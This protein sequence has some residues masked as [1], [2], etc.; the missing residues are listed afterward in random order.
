[1]YRAHIIGGE[2]RVEED[3][4][5]DDVAWHTTE[6]IDALDRVPLVDMSRRWAGLID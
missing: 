1:V 4:S 5:T 2:L 6:E 3:G